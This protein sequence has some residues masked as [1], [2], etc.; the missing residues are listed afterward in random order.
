MNK[1]DKTMTYLSP[2]I[3]VVTFK[4]EQG[5]QVSPLRAEPLGSSQTGTEDVT[6]GSGLGDYFTRG[7]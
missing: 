7:N 5:F 6:E 4:I 2:K 1:Q 3:T